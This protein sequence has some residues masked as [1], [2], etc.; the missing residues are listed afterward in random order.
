M[1]HSQYTPKQKNLRNQVLKASGY[2]CFYCGNEA[3]NVEFHGANG[4]ETIATCS[5]CIQLINAT[6][7]LQDVEPADRVEYLAT[8]RN[9]KGIGKDQSWSLRPPGYKPRPD[10]YAPKPKPR[11]KLRERLAQRNQSV[12]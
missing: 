9:D 7:F 4:E 3:H 12:V 2:M 8:L 6:P 10:I 5:P 11:S 1:P